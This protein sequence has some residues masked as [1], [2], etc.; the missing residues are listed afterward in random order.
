MERR[1]TLASVV[2]CS[3]KFAGSAAVSFTRYVG[4]TLFPL[5]GV[6]KRVSVEHI[7]EDNPGAAARLK[8]IQRGAP[9]TSGLRVGERSPSSRGADASASA[10]AAAGDVTSRLTV[11]GSGGS[12]GGGGDTERP[13]NCLDVTAELFWSMWQWATRHL[14]PKSEHALVNLWFSVPL[15]VFC[16]ALSAARV[17]YTATGYVCCCYLWY[18]RLGGSSSLLTSAPSLRT[19]TAVGVAEI[20][21]GRVLRHWFSRRQMFCM[22]GR[23]RG[24]G[25]CQCMQWR[26]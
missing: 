24:V 5:V 2:H 15:M 1:V 12:G 4:A 14:D 10:G 21:F 13:R 11:A 8:L 16:N 18:E 26:G 17:A 20:A 6:M 3:A 25:Q 7:A 23:P 22:K 9:D 19:L